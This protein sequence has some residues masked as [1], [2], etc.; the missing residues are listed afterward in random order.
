[1]TCKNSDCKIIIFPST[2]AANWIWAFM[3][4]E[5]VVFIKSRSAVNSLWSSCATKKLTSLDYQLII[6]S[7]MFRQIYQ[8]IFI[9]DF[10]NQC[11]KIILANRFK[12]LLIH[13][14]QSKLFRGQFSRQD[15]SDVWECWVLVLGNWITYHLS[16]KLCNNGDRRSI[17][18]IASEGRH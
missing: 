16:H 1:M 17:L 2:Y 4:S 18:F 5:R 9:E 11:V 3:P 6:H 15:Y 13:N 8:F 10:V 14:P 12:F 7:S